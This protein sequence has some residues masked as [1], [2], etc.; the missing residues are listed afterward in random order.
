MAALYGSTFTNANAS[1]YIEAT[2]QGLGEST[3]GFF[4]IVSYS[5]Y[6]S[7]LQTESTD[8][9]KAFVPASQPSIFGGGDVSITSTLAQALGITDATHGGGGTPNGIL[10][11][12]ADGITSC[13]TPGT[14]GCYSGII[15][16]NDP[17]DLDNSQT[18]GQGYT[19]ESL[20]GSTNGTTENYDFFAVVEHELDEVLGT[21]SCIGLTDSGPQNNCFGASSAVDQF[22]YS[23]SGVR[24]WDSQSPTDQY[25]SANGGVTDLDGN[26]YNTTKSGED[27]ADLVRVVFSF[28][29]PRLARATILPLIASASSRTV[30]AVQSGRKWPLLNAV[31]YDLK[32]QTASTP[33]PA[34]MG[35]LGFG[36]T[37]LGGL[38]LPPA[39]S[40]VRNRFRLL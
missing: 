18:H 19:Y 25:F 15:F 30:P 2:N 37:A 38:A 7:A 39:A 10:G 21:A 3:S 1:V 9:A 20:G 12:E 8:A 6:Q 26:L 17:T 11:I 5:A 32:T 31:G 27:W 35:L 24:A 14:A 4:N 23:A 36:L 16:V 13:T 40:E 28:R 29:T 22:R 33:E 34:S